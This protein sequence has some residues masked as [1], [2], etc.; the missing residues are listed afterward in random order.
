[1]VVGVTVNISIKEKENVSFWLHS[2]PHSLD[3]VEYDYFV[4][5]AA[6]RSIF[7]SIV[8]QYPIGGYKGVLAK[9]WVVDDEY[10]TWKFKLRTD[11]KFDN[12]DFITPQH[13]ITSLKRIAFLQLKKKSRPILFKNMI[14]IDKFSKMNDVIEGLQII[15]N[16]TLLMKYSGSFKNLLEVISF[17]LYAI[18][19]PNDFDKNDGTWKNS[20][21]AISS[22]AYKIK[23]WD[24]ERIQLSLRTDFGY[25]DHH[26]SRFKQVSI[27]WMANDKEQSDIV[28]QPSFATELSSLRL[29]FVGPVPS[30]IMYLRCDSWNQEGSICSTRQNRVALRESFYESF[31]ASG[32]KVVRSFFPLAMSGITE[33]KKI[34]P[35][36]FN[37]KNTNKKLIFK[38]SKDN[39]SAFSK[40][41]LSVATKFDL[42]FFNE[43]IPL[44]DAYYFLENEKKTNFD[45]FLYSTG[46][47]LDDPEHDIEFMFL[48]KEGVILPDEDGTITTDLKKGLVNPQRINQI[49]FDQAIIWPIF[50]YSNGIWINENID[51][52]M[53]DVVQPPIDFNWVGAI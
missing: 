2:A 16:D 43:K 49:I 15:D 36:S 34:N 9:S 18:V 31:Q 41:L 25:E 37:I 29:K 5:H 27:S 23:F 30:S 38:Y 48:T 33:I 51:V 47:L 17:G 46:I 24:E 35:L 19:H 12:G 14:G 50:H 42:D 40:S 28:L 11:L 3:P 45:I 22:A 21:S 44:K 6:F 13:V 20:K 8:T 7:S 1:M 53:L 32:G 26:K 4:H 52:S 39:V 10:K